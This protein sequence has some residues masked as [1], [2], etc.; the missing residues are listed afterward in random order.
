[1]QESPVAGSSEPQRSSELS[2]ISAEAFDAAVAENHAWVDNLDQEAAKATLEAHEQYRKQLAARLSEANRVEIYLLDFTMTPTTKPAFPIWP[3]SKEA[4][5]L[6]QTTVPEEAHELFITQLAV[7][8]NH[9]SGLGGAFCHFPIHGV[10]LYHDSTI[11]FESSLCWACVNI[12][13]AY[14]DGPAFSPINES[15]AL[16]ELFIAAMPIPPEEH[17]RFEAYLS[18]DNTH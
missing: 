14:P 13:V 6:A 18:K 15:H 1:M 17:E 3:Y 11:I 7:A 4:R 16:Y 9:P 12:S 10:R 8:L 5:I 2:R